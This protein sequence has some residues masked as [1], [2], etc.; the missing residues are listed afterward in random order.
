M[1]P[2]LG[3][4]SRELQRHAEEQEQASSVEDEGW[5]GQAMDWLSE[6]GG[7]IVDGI[8]GGVDW[9]GDR[10]SDG[11]DWLGD[12]IQDGRDFLGTA[13]DAIRDLE[14]PRVTELLVGGLTGLVRG[15]GDVIELLTG[16]DLR[17]ADDGTGYADAPRPSPPSNP[18]WWRQATS[19]RSSP[20]PT[21]PTATSRPAR[22]R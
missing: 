15:T 1:V 3:E 20:T 22:S 12:R 10:F 8:R 17:W 18:A 14:W 21:R 2:G 7:G 19:R 11:M 16:H 5:F 4:R 13:I 9:L 6:T